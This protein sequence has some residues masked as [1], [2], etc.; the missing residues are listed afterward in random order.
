VLLLLLR[1][2]AV[3]L[4]ITKIHKF[5]SNRKIQSFNRSWKMH[6]ERLLVDLLHRNCDSRK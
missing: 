5:R 6:D 2:V 1:L 4:L 3:A